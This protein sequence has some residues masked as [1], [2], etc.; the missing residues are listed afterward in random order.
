M[1][2]YTKIDKQLV[3]YYEIIAINKNLSDQNY[4][5]KR[6]VLLLLICYMFMVIECF[7]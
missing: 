1:G 7:I 2:L 6:L 3:K 5:L 4:Y